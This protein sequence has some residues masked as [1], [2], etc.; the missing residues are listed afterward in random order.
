METLIYKSTSFL[1]V[2]LSQ[3]DKAF[4]V[5][6]TPVT[7]LVPG[8]N[9]PSYSHR[10]KDLLNTKTLLKWIILKLISLLNFSSCLL[11]QLHWLVLIQNIVLPL[12][13]SWNNPEK[14]RRPTFS[15]VWVPTEMSRDYRLISYQILIDYLFN[16]S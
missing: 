10:C 8:V 11:V 5:P 6:V 4:G 16:S 1:R 14:H 7:L 15:N 13:I 2:T 12:K 9:T 3:Y